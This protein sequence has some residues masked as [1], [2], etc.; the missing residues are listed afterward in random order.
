[1]SQGKV[2]QIIGPVLDLD[3]PNG[4]LPAILNALE[5][6]LGDGKTL[7]AEVAQHL[8]ENRVRTVAMD[9]TEGLVRGMV[10]TNTGGA[11]ASVV[12]PAPSPPAVTATGSAEAL[13]TAFSSSSG[14]G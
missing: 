1:M 4:E 5:V 2:T 6:D 10:V 7:V 13:H 9:S 14:C 8:G 3:F 11:A 12:L